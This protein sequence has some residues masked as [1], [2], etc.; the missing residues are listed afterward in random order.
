MRFT[1]MFPALQSIQDVI[2]LRFSYFFLTESHKLNALW[3]GLC[4]VCAV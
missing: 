2:A 3:V 1:S 4:G